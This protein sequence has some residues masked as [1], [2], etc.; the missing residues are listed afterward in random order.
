MLLTL[1]ILDS[2]CQAGDW[3]CEQDLGKCYCLYSESVSWNEAKERCASLEPNGLAT[4]AS[5]RSYRENDVISSFLFLY[6]WIGGTD[7]EAEGVW[8]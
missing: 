2:G 1:K 4:L 5:V 6:L 8:R 3:Q 7:K